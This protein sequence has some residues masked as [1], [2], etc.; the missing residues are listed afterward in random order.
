[1]WRRIKREADE[2]V[3]GANYDIAPRCQNISRSGEKKYE[4]KKLPS[5]QVRGGNWL[6]PG[7][8]RCLNTM[9]L[10]YQEQRRWRR[11]RRHIKEVQVGIRHQ[12]LVTSTAT[13]NWVNSTAM[14]ALRVNSPANG[15]DFRG[16]DFYFFIPQANFLKYKFMTC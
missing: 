11:R 7:G 10:I 6:S 2:R 4:K 12:R 16:C 3:R 14:A 8:F 9:G 1:M 15:F 13:S 5:V